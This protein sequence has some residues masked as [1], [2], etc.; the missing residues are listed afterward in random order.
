[1]SHDRVEKRMT[2]IQR[3][4][5]N[6][7]QESRKTDGNVLI[8][9]S[10]DDHQQILSRLIPK[11]TETVLVNLKDQHRNKRFLSQLVKRE[12]FVSNQILL[13]HLEK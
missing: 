3:L 2:N 4:L 11:T 8:I 9:T 6:A 5:S 10:V 12:Y 7:N 13:F 1:M